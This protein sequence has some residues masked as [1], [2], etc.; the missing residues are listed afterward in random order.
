MGRTFA[1]RFVE[2]G[3]LGGT[4]GPN[5]YGANPLLRAKPRGLTARRIG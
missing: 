1:G 4:A 5:R 2:I 3:Y